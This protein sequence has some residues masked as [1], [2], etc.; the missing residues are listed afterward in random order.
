MA[1]A[2]AEPVLQ[3]QL[4]PGDIIIFDDKRFR[5]GATPLVGSRRRAAQRDA[6]VCTVDYPAT[7]LEAVG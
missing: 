4:N 5:H 6:L 7:Y 3:Q 1:C 2:I